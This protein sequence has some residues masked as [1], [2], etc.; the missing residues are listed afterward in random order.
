MGS[1]S[2]HY[3]TTTSGAKNMIVKNWLDIRPK[4][5]THEPNVYP[6]ILG[7]VSRGFWTPFLALGAQSAIFWRLKT[8]TFAVFKSQKMASRAPKSKNGVQKPGETPPQNGGEDIWFMRFHFRASIK[9]ILDNH[10]FRPVLHVPLKGQKTKTAG[11]LSF[12][13]LCC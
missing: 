3:Y 2:D 1:T 13:G 9:P 11:R 6:T 10:V 12:I 8:G 5:E 4:M 7:G